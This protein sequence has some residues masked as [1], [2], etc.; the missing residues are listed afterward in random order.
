MTQILE[1]KINPEEDSLDYRRFA[2]ICVADSQT[3]T[4]PSTTL[5]LVHIALLP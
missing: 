4:E 5:V 2:S 3:Q 1:I